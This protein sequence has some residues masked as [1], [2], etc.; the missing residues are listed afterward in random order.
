MPFRIF[1]KSWRMSFRTKRRLI[2]FTSAY[3]VLMMWIAQLIRTFIL[4]PS[5]ELLSTLAYSLG[6]GAIMGIIF[7]WWLAHG[8]RDDV[9][10]LKCVGWSNHNIREL[11][12]GEVIFIT[13]SALISLTIIAI[14]FSGV[15]FT[16]YVGFPP[17]GTPISG[18]T[19][20][21]VIPPIWFL[22]VQ[23][24]YMWGAFAI[25]MLSQ[26]PGILL[27]TWRILRISPMRALTRPE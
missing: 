26:V 17:L 25:V 11:I 24:H 6:A 7:S 23:P 19:E 22:V 14:G 5:N 18:P 21:P 1:F 3:A 27:L 16:L 20:V 2:V 8:R 9:A 10:V 4:A 12:L 15:W 13:F